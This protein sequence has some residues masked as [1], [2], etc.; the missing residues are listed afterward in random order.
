MALGWVRYGDHIILQEQ[1][2]PA[3]TWMSLRLNRNN[4]SGSFAALGEL[5]RLHSL[6][7]SENNLS[8]P[9]PP[10]LGSAPVMSGRRPQTMHARLEVLLSTNN[11]SGPWPASAGG[12]GASATRPA[13]SS[14][15]TA[16]PNSLP[17]PS[18]SNCGMNSDD[19]QVQP[20]RS[21]ARAGLAR[22]I[23]RLAAA[24]DFPFDPDLL[25][26]VSPIEWKNV[27]LYGEIKID[28][29]KLKT[30][31][32]TLVA[33]AR[34]VVTW[35]KRAG[36]SPSTSTAPA[37]QIKRRAAA[38]G[39]PPSRRA[40]TRSGRR[41]PRARAADR[42]DDREPVWDAR[43]HYSLV[44]DVGGIRMLFTASRSASIANT[45]VLLISISRAAYC[46]IR[47][48]TSCRNVA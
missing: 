24:P 19:L 32:G 15:G 14:C 45:L 21:G 2:H 22:E 3:S 34:P 42:G 23:S 35:S 20:A 7:L 27:I 43:H 39:L 1:E 44:R 10:E 46:V 9:I 41:H 30:R 5:P 26:H 16:T 6:E 11:L 47:S 31:R 36:S 29:A 4:I 12:W 13:R 18:L 25:R 33:A 40:A 8:G 17:W 48:S 37:A 28:P 38:T